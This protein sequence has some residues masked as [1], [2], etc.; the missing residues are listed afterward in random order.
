MQDALL[1]L[2]YVVGLSTL[3][4][5]QLESARITGAETPTLQDGLAILRYLVRLP[6]P[7]LDEVWPR[8]N[9][10]TVPDEEPDKEVSE[11]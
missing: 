4:D 8:E 3:T 6:S 11:A 10:D 5:Y 9:A 2:R 7:Q 1:I